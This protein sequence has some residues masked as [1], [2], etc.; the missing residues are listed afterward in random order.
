METLYCVILNSK[1]ELERANPLNTDEIAIIYGNK[2]ECDSY[3]EY[4]NKSKTLNNK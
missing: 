1:G 2:T 4:M 3:I